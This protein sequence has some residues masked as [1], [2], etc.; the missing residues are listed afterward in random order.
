MF[1]IDKYENMCYIYVYILIFILVYIYIR[2]DI[3]DMSS[4]NMVLNERKGKL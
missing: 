2:I 4:E 1:I 3:D